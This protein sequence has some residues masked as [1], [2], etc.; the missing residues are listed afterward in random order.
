MLLQPVETLELLQHG[1][2]GAKLLER[3]LGARPGLLLWAA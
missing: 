2:L 3:C 1:A